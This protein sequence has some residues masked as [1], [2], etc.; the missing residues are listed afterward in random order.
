MTSHAPSQGRRIP[1][2]ALPLAGLVLPLWVS[3]AG[4]QSKPQG[5][6][7]M[8]LDE[9]LKVQ[10]LVVSTRGDDILTAPSTVTVIDADTI[11]RYNLLSIAEA[12]EL[13]PGMDVKR[14]YLKRNLATARG[15]LQDHYANKV[16]VLI[17]GVPTWHASTGEGAFYRIP[18]Q[19]VERIEVLRG[20][21]SVLYGTNAYSG[22]IN[23]V[24]RRPEGRQA[25]ADVGLAERGGYRAGGSAGM[26]LGGVSVLASAH[27]FGDEG[28]TFTFTDEKKV[29]GPVDEF[30]RGQ[31]FT[32]TANGK[33]H[34]LLA[35]VFTYDESFLGTTPTFAAGVGY[36]HVSDGRLL[37]YSYVHDI[38]NKGRI[39]AGL[40][41]DWGRRDFSRSRDDSQAS[42]VEAYR[43]LGFVRSSWTPSSRWGMD[44]GLDY[45]Y[46]KSLDY[47]IYQRATGA[48]ST[49]NN[50]ENRSVT[51]Y[52]AYGELTHTRERLSLR[53]GSRLTKNEFFGS[54]VSSR[55]AAVFTVNDRNSL[56]LIWGQSYRA[57]SLF[58][59][60]FQTPQ[61]TV[62]GNLDLQ[63][64]T[65]SSVELA[66]VTTFRGLFLQAL[67]YHA[68]YDNKIARVPRYPRFVSDP[69]DTSTVYVNGDGFKADGLEVDL[70]YDRPRLVTA[71]LSLDYVKGDSG[72]ALPGSNHYNFRYVPKL[73]LSAGLAKSVRG[74]SVSAIVNHQTDTEGTKADVP[75]HTTLDAS[76]GYQHGLGRLRVQHSVYAKNALDEEVLTPEYVRGILND[77]PMDLG[78]R[79]G[80]HLRLQF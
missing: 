49:Q 66:Y 72:D 2:L 17:N 71:F 60:Y 27:A 37:G 46:R 36:P 23:I 45:G 73:S 55:A 74:V 9:L 30:E 31:L 5:Y 29:K 22:A 51:E 68:S 10:I 67:V 24:L 79:I 62:Y 8:S 4:A 57:P 38:S 11:R 44:L 59:L 39:T 19:D 47:S 69:K 20:P 52:S 41:Y 63:P 61:N 1:W 64:E 54:N 18:I 26:V 21:A 78:R 58:E 48:I 6:E 50:M 15:M 35:N 7:G 53:L 42:S 13:V 75:A 3:A 32:L 70:R 80:Y 77:V 40:V 43:V 76:L 16:L 65:S 28:R 33:G 14:T 56:K 34:A 25:Q 12:L